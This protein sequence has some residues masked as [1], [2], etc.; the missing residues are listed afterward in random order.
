MEGAGAPAY[1]TPKA[2]M[3]E[4]VPQMQDILGVDTYSLPI[5]W[6]A[7]FLYGPKTAAGGDTYVLCESNVSAVWSFPP[8]AL[9]RMAKA[10]LER[11]Q[12][13]EVSSVG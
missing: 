11:I 3:Q 9:E 10:S 7:D 12:A 2:K 13:N 8:S 1:Q 6:D 4:W 5:I